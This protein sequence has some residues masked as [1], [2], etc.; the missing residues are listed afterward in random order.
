MTFLISSLIPTTPHTGSACINKNDTQALFIECQYNATIN[1][2]NETYIQFEG[3]YCGQR[4]EGVGCDVV[5]NPAGSCVGSA[6]MNESLHRHCDG[7]VNCSIP[8]SLVMHYC[9][10]SECGNGS[11]YVSWRCYNRSSLELDGESLAVR[12][13]FLILGFSDGPITRPKWAP[14]AYP[15]FADSTLRESECGQSSCATTPATGVAC[16]TFLPVD[17][18][19]ADEYYGIRI[20]SGKFADS[21]ERCNYNSD[22]C[23]EHDDYYSVHMANRHRS[24]ELRLDKIL[25]NGAYWHNYDFCT[26]P[27]V[28]FLSVRFACDNFLTET[29]VHCSENTRVSAS[30]STVMRHPDSRHSDFNFNHKLA[31][32]TVNAPGKF[33][34]EALEWGFLYPTQ[35]ANEVLRWGYFFGQDAIYVHI[36]EASW[37]YSYPCLKD[38]AKVTKDWLFYDIT[39]SITVGRII[40]PKNWPL[41]TVRYESI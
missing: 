35:R 25:R 30:N 6:W 1:P 7:R 37:G 33:H 41:G 2:T 18:P 38:S 11:I 21:N 39:V 36:L 24:I 31:A 4:E 12:T 26:P 32:L 20:I 40:T 34:Y 27:E 5:G 15:A 13:C 10:F 17:C 22:S 19:I 16:W 29:S 9:E 14:I 3:A 28:A 23:I 8:T